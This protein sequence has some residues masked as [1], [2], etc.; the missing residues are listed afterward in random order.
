[1]NK[2]S[3]P[4]DQSRDEHTKGKKSGS[5]SGA[6]FY[7]RLQLR[8]ARTP[9]PGICIFLCYKLNDKSEFIGLE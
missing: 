7:K 5:G 8:T 2:I 3:I 1:M 6:G 9:S 4:M